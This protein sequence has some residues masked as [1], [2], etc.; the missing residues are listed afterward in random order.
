MFYLNSE[1]C[2]PQFQLELQKAQGM[3]LAPLQY[4]NGLGNWLR[5]VLESGWMLFKGNMTVTGPVCLLVLFG[6]F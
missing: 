6:V 3:C 5:L 2:W 4:W 1:L